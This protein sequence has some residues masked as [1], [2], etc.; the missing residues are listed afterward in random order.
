MRGGNIVSGFSLKRAFQRTK[1]IT[2]GQILFQEG[3]GGGQGGFDLFSAVSTLFLGHQNYS[4]LLTELP[5]IE[6][7]GMGV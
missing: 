6:T 2:F 4:F 7:M 1:K 3:E 5:C